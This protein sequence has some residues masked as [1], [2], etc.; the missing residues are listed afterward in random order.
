MYPVSPA[1]L[2]ALG[3]SHTAAVRVDVDWPDGTSSTDVPVFAGQVTV[4]GTAKIRRIL[5][6]EVQ[7]DPRWTAVLAGAVV[8]PYRGVRFVD[9][10][11][12]MVPLGVFHVRQ[13][14]VDLAGLDRVKLTVPDRWRYVQ[15]GRFYWPM[16][17]VTGATIAAEWH[18]IVRATLPAAYVTSFANLSGSTQVIA[19]TVWPRDRDNAAEDLATS[20][21]CEGFFDVTGQPTLRPVTLATAA[22]AWTVQAGPGG[23]VFGG[24]RST[25]DERTY[26][27]VVV[28]PT[29]TDGTAPF[30]PQVVEDNDPT[31][32]TYAHGPFGQVPRFYGS[33]VVTNASQALVVATALLAKVTGIARTLTLDSVV[34]PALDAGDVIEL[35]GNGLR[36]RHIVDAFTVPLTVEDKMTLTTRSQAPVP[37]DEP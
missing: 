34:N 3:T 26:S 20:L 35:R 8:K 30:P 25:T 17:S 27:A 18:R 37:P 4:D 9:G 31:S 16:S 14:D 2:A 11:T 15:R 12:E 13:E 5:T 29:R 7:A 19:P 24:Q 22:T 28:S 10:S 1:F 6:L 21:G 23:A 36:E 32:P 33:P